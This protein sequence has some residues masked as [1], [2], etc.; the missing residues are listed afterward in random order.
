MMASHGQADLE[1][2]TVSPPPRSSK[3]QQRVLACVLCQ[4]RKVKCNRRF[5]CSNCV[6]AQIECMPATLT[7][8]RKRR[9]VPNDR[10]LLGRILEYEELL[11]RNKVEFEPLAKTRNLAGPR[12]GGGGGSGGGAQANDGHMDS[13]HD[14][15]EAARGGGPSSSSPTTSAATT[16]RVFEAK[17]VP[18]LKLRLQPRLL[19]VV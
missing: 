4:Q 5:P 18:P 15:S 17:Y 9:P 2:P 7:P 6:K 10:E 14:G 13:D 19:L 12:G 3:L 8:R 16:E 1:S 11:R